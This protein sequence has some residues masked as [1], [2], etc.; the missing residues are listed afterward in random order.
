MSEDP[1]GALGSAWSELELLL[2]S[3]AVKAIG[4]CNTP[5]ALLRPLLAQRKAAG[6]VSCGQI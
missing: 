6:G 3:G 5:G 4:L 2:A 1:L